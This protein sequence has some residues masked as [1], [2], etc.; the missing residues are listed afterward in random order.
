MAIK[1][2][3]GDSYLYKSDEGILDNLSKIRADHIYEDAVQEFGKIK[4]IDKD[5]LDTWYKRGSVANK[6]IIKHNIDFKEK[7]FFW[8]MLYGATGLRVPKSSKKSRNDFKT[9]SV[10]SAYPLSDLKKAGSWGLWREVVGSSSIISDERVASWVTEKIIKD[11]I[12]RDNARPLLKYVRNRLKELDTTVLS[13]P[14]LYTK[15][16]SENWKDTSEV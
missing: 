1:I 7:K 6:L 16:D 15:L 11:K 10:L 9:A 13:E 3:K 2:K 14:E 4:Y 8:I 5:A 12:S